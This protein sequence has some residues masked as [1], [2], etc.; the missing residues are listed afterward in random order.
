ME[1][2]WIPNGSNLGLFP[3]TLCKLPQL[4]RTP[5]LSL[6]LSRPGSPPSTSPSRTRERTPVL[7]GAH[8]HTRAVLSRSAA[9][10]GPQPSRRGGSSGGKRKPETKGR[11]TR[12]GEVASPR[13]E[14]E[15]AA[16]SGEEHRRR[17]TGRGRRNEGKE[18][19]GNR[20][21]DH[22]QLQRSVAQHGQCTIPRHVN[23]FSLHTCVAGVASCAVR[24]GEGW[25]AERALAGG[26]RG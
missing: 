20:K 26:E 11:R 15:R 25:H 8:T 6:S 10:A 1:A 21:R 19:R 4:K 13:T 22:L 7:A 3:G 23:P 12:E 9:A 14:R 17:G 16:H 5:S 24:A 18:R 2:A